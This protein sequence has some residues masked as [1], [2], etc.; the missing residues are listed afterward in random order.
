MFAVAGGGIQNFE[1]LY[2][3]LNSDKAKNP[4]FFVLNIL[5]LGAYLVSIITITLQRTEQGP[6]IEKNAL[7]R[8]KKYSTLLQ[9]MQFI[10]GLLLNKSKIDV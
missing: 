10:P 3:F 6:I 1:I 4:L 2:K 8:N 5:S 9:W 7:R